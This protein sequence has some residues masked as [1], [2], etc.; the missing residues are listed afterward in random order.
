MTCCNIGKGIVKMFEKRSLP[1]ILAAV[2][3]IIVVLMISPIAA[4]SGRYT[5]LVFG[6]PCTFVVWAAG[7][8]ALAILGIILGIWG[9][10]QLD[11]EVEK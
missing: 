4:P 3:G 1:R 10:R 2:A 8:L 11:R 6:F 5:P 9:L 7:S